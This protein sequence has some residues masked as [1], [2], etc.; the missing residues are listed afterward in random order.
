MEW[1]SNTT[2]LLKDIVQIQWD[3]SLGLTEVSTAL[4]LWQRRE[5]FC[6]VLASLHSKNTS[7]LRKIHT[8]QANAW[9]KLRKKDVRC[10]VGWIQKIQ[11]YRREDLCLS[12]FIFVFCLY[13]LLLNTS[14][15]RGSRNRLRVCCSLIPFKTSIEINVLSWS[16]L[17][18]ILANLSMYSVTAYSQKMLY[19]KQVSNKVKE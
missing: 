6:G 7:W 19:G 4:I 10:L 18:P 17:C 14:L 8:T 16:G 12:L 1:V 5:G 3:A 11:P 15:T 13:L 2:E 9:D